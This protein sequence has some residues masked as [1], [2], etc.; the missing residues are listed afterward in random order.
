MKNGFLARYVAL[1]GANTMSNL[2][3]IAKRQWLFYLLAKIADISLVRRSL[4]FLLVISLSGCTRAEAPSFSLLGSY[5]PSW[6]ACA[7]IGVIVAVIARILFIR[8]GIDDVLPWR[9]F[10]YACL[11]LAVAFMFSLILFVR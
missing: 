9:L 6:L 8:I 1:I 7:S 2:I 5:F 10:V 3:S 11:A 4:W